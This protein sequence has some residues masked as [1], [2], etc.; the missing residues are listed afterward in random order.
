MNFRRK[1]KTAAEIWREGGG[2]AIR[3][4]LQ[5]KISQINEAR[6]YQEWIKKY[7]SLTAADCAAIRA[8]IE[9]FDAKPLISVV[10]P[11]YNVDERWLRLAVESVRRQLYENWELCIAD[12]CSPA[13][14]VKRVLDEYAAKDWRIKTVFRETN[15]HISAASNSALRLAS[16]EFCALL[17]HDDELSPAALYYVAEEI[18]KYPFVD[19]IYSDEDMIDERGRRYQ[20]K[21]KPDWSPD[22]FYSLNLIT[23]LSV[24]RTDVLRRI[25]GFRLGVEGSQDY[26]LALRVIEQIPVRNIRHIPHILYHWRA[27]PGSVALDAD[28][29]SY[30]HDRART[31]IQEHFDRTGV[32]ASIASG[33]KTLHR[34]IYELPEPKPL[35]SVV[36]LADKLTELTIESI[37]KKTDYRP[38]QIVVVGNQTEK[39][40]FK[41]A[42]A[43]VHFVECDSNSA[44]EKFNCAAA[45][46]DGEVLIFLQSGLLVENAD[47]LRELTSHALRREIGAA[48]GKIVYSN[49]HI[50]H[51]GLILRR[52][53]TIANAHHFLSPRSYGHFARAKV[54][55]NFSAVSAECLAIRRQ[56]FLDAA[57]FNS[58]DLPACYYAVDLCL[59]LREKSGL[60]TIWTPYAEFAQSRELEKKQ[61]AKDAQPICEIE[62]KH[63]RREWKRFFE[64]DPFY[65]PNLD[66]RSQNFAVRM[67]PHADLRSFRSYLKNQ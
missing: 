54:I 31:A 67:P 9:K 37:E 52:D 43:R 66:E 16:G 65:N 4:H 41:S 35:V 27:I 18:N 32:R 45:A 28:E 48:G 33:F 40:Q 63:L 59:R 57:K 6:K 29:K 55:N 60:R 1:F 20:P 34:A 64:N 12:D 7:D 49:K 58:T 56:V 47:W 39:P 17:D 30:A 53:F 36:L 38:F 24:Y 10:M 23:H 22:L 15:G 46:S 62:L 42:R 26:D 50:R 11:V 61:R 2:W 14:H 21:F 19:M 51:A 8:R 5:S 25:N 13:P 44:A 3:K